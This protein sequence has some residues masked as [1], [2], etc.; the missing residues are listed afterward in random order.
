MKSAI[1]AVSFGTTHSDAE[2]GC[3]A[4]V[5]DALRAAFPDR[6]VRRAW[7]ARF[8]RAALERRGE[9]VD[10]VSE[11]IARL[12]AEGFSN[13]ALAST[14]IIRG[15]EYALAE[16][17]AEGLP[18]SAP[19]LDGE[20]DLLWM[21]ELLD[22]IAREEGRTLLVMGHGTDHAANAVYAGLRQRLSPRVKLACVEGEYGLDGLWDALEAVPGKRLTLMPLM[23]VAGD[24]A[25]NDL[26]GE[27]EDSWRSRLLARG[28]DVALRL[29]GLGSLEAVRRRIVEKARAAAGGE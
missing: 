19:L 5:E 10:G 21:A 17:E 9:H 26:A 7:T 13:I 12:R 23:L 28:F 20:D 6:Q 2:A 15:R 11:A 29:R 25:K 27:G 14:H 1:I 3:I 22:G 18:L 24:H 4:P 8:I 16:A